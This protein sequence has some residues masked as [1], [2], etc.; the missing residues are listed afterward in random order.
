MFEFAVVAKNLAIHPQ[1]EMAVHARYAERSLLSEPYTSWRL[2]IFG[3]KSILLGRS[4]FVHQGSPVFRD[5]H[6]FTCLDGYL[7]S[8][9]LAARSD[10]VVEQVHQILLGSQD[11]DWLSDCLGEFL[12]VHYNDRRRLL[13]FLCSELRTVPLYL[14]EGKDAVCVSNRASLCNVGFEGKPQLDV[15]GQL[16]H[17][18]VLESLQGDTT[19]FEQVRSLPRDRSARLRYSAPDNRQGAPELILLERERSWAMPGVEVPTM[20]EVLEETRSITTWL[21]EHL[22]LFRK[23]VNVHSGGKYGL[24][25]GKDSRLVLALLAESGLIELYDAVY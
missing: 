15:L 1:E 12:I 19:A 24:S 3:D 25:G 17:V 22:R 6:S 8:E 21:L 16:A 9:R 14:R 2:P 7:V 13:E 18:A 10:D 23:Q 5:Q 11:R 20:E 4:R